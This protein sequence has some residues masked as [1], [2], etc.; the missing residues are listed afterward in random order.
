MANL[1]RCP[2]CGAANHVFAALNESLLAISGNLALDAVLQRVVD[3]ARGL[4]HASF[5]AV[6]VADERQRLRHLITS[7]PTGSSADADAA[8]IFPALLKSDTPYATSD[9][10]SDSRFAG[11]P[12]GYPDLKSFLS[13]PIVAAGE[14]VGRFYLGNENTWG[15]TPEHRGLVELLAP[16][17][18]IAITN[19]RLYEQS[20]ELSV[21]QERNRLARELH[22]SVT[23]TM[24]SMKLAAESATVLVDKDATAARTQLLHMQELARQASS[25]MRSLIFELRPP[26]L[27]IEG[28]VQ[29]L[30]KHIDVLA[31]VHA[32][33]IELHHRGDGIVDPAQE[34]EVFRVVQEALN[35]AIRH[36]D[37]DRI[38]V[39][40]V[41]E[42]DKLVVSVS[43]DGV[44]FDP[45]AS[46][47]TRR[48]GLV[49]MNERAQALGAELSIS[50]AVGRGTVVALELRS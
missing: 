21:V 10:Q 22:D 32:V 16:H 2:E 20:R 12:P 39:D 37:A 33:D 36:A 40:V 31:R 47:N 8:G 41:N 42:V 38:V 23:Q 26:E 30:A 6:G 11:W 25:E 14:I 29:T 46:R 15:F 9:V 19:A 28:L 7:P 18:G 1:F 45:S 13:V 49:S 35:N 43:D 5:G 4:I 27:E 24:F 44:G 17:A 3:V 50:S 34:A 48:L